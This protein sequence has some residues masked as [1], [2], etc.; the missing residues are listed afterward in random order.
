M[1]LMTILW[2]AWLM[3]MNSRPRRRFRE[4]SSAAGSLQSVQ[5]EPRRVIYGRNSRAPQ[6]HVENVTAASF[7]RQ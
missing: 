1:I 5:P 6:Q 7:L 3:M 4:G 2:A